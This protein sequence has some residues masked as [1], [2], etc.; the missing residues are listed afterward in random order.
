MGTSALPD[1]YAR[2]PRAEDIHIRQSTIAPAITT[3]LKIC[4]NLDYNSSLYILKDT[5]CDC[6]IIL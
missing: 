5:H 3:T 2:N 4:L 6:G 1:M